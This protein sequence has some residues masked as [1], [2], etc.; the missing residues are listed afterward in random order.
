MSALA[1]EPCEA[2]TSDDDPLTAAEYEPYLD[3][4][5]ADVWEVVDDHHH[6]EGHYEFD[7]FRDAL[8]FTYEI[9]ELAEEEWHHPD[10]ALAWGEVDVKMWTHKI[11]GLHKTDF[12]MA[13]RMDRIHEDYAPDE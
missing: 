5:R 3:G 8:E 11:D 13:A 10:I 6:L 1:D 7:D 12:V 4:I 2:C 9:G